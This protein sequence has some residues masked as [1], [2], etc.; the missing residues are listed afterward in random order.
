MPI[1][2]PLLTISDNVDDNFRYSVI[3]LMVPIPPSLKDYIAEEHVIKWALFSK[4]DNRDFLKQ[5]CYM[6]CAEV[7]TTTKIEKRLRESLNKFGYL[8]KV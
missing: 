8:L 1:E 5:S 6:I 7:V 2:K 3:E 4:L